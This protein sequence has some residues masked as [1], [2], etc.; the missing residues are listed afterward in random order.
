MK[1]A[2]TFTIAVV[3]TLPVFLTGQ[4]T[5]ET[6]IYRNEIGTDFT[7]LLNQVLFV[8]FSQN[9]QEY[10]PI[11]YIT[12]KRLLKNFN[13]R[14]GI[15]GKTKS[16]TFPV[17]YLPDKFN[18]SRS[19]TID[20][21]LG[22]EKSS[23]LG[24]RWNFHYGLDFRHTFSKSHQDNYTSKDGWG[25]GFDEHGR[26]LAIAPIM[27]IEFKINNRISLLTEAN[28]TAY[29]QREERK[30]FYFQYPDDPSAEPQPKVEVDVSKERGTEFD[31]PRF[32]IIAV[33]I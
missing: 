30:P 15:G 9:Y 16:N 19:S 12:Y 33:K 13:I 28:F 20:Y 17:D 1:L 24:K 29:F 11:Y 32:I 22:I 6:K 25:E 18:T 5:I 21:R 26:V 7:T 4:D 23:E 27:M 8:N 2:F 31:V 14:F 10:Q 3:L